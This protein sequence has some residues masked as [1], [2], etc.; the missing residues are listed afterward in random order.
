MYMDCT[1]D[2]SRLRG[3]TCVMEHT[4]VENEFGHNISVVSTL[5]SNQGGS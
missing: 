4:G 3:H 1:T 2:S 5:A